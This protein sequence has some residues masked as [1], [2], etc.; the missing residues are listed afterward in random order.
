MVFLQWQGH[1]IENIPLIMLLYTW[2]DIIWTSTTAIGPCETGFAFTQFVISK[3]NQIFL[4]KWVNIL[5]ST[6]T[7]PL[8]WNG[9]G[10]EQFLFQ[11]VE[12]QNLI[13]GDGSFSLLIKRGDSIKSV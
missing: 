9:E 13:Q 10:R 6:L 2:I 12:N 1:E 11:N 8:I 5:Q 3:F 4:Q 7:F